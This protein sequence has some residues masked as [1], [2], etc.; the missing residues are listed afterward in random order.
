[1]TEYQRPCHA[2]CSN[3]DSGYGELRAKSSGNESA[4]RGLP[5]SWVRHPVENCDR[6]RLA[7]ECDNQG[8]DSDAHQIQLTNTA[9]QQDGG[10]YNNRRCSQGIGQHTLD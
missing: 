10:R 2:G 3:Y 9:G 8:G 1:M 7:D 5:T 6:G 4:P